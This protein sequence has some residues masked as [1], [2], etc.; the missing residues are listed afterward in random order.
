MEKRH[1]RESTE[2]PLLDTSLTRRERGGHCRELGEAGVGENLGASR[3]NQSAM[4]LQ[5][6]ACSQVSDQAAIG[7]EEVVFG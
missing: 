6:F 1:Q 3:E 5:Q 4:S 2:N 7:S